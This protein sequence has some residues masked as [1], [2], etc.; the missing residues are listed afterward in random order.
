M[1]LLIL[2]A[3]ALLMKLVGPLNY[4]ALVLYFISRSRSIAS[5]TLLAAFVGGNDRSYCYGCGDG[6]LRPLSGKS[7][8]T[9]AHAQTSL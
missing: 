7:L 2:A 8:E 9:F 3:L 4:V 6:E 5:K 1:T